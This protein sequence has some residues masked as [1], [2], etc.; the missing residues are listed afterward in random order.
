M[1]EAPLEEEAAPAA[2]P[3]P[4]LAP[5]PAAAAT[6]PTPVLSR[7]PLGDRWAE[8][9][10]ALVAGNAIGALV[11]ELAMQAE[12]VAIEPGEGAAERWRLVVEREP[13]R[14][15]AP[16]EKLQAA[17]NATGLNLRLEVAAGSP[18]D[19][20]ARREAEATAQRQ[21][22]AEAIIQSD[23]LVQTMLAQFST[24]RIV[25]GSIRPA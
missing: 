17:L 5:A 22:Q 25:P 23:P 11:R 24:A 8:V 21:R 9:V 6:T 12:L 13:L 3:R 14:A 19:S 15:A 7:T 2:A 1:D 18:S 4:T 10:S 16:V 20:P